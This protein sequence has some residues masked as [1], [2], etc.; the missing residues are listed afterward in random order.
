MFL[1]SLLVKKERKTDASLFAPI[2]FQAMCVWSFKLVCEP[3]RDPDPVLV[4][5]CSELMMELRYTKY[6]CKVLHLQ[7]NSTS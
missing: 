5:F 1:W 6:I 2:Y 4:V 3:V 7:H